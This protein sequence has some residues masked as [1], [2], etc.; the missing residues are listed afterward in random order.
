MTVKRSLHALKKPDA[1]WSV[2]N[3]AQKNIYGQYIYIFR[4]A[5]QVEAKGF[6]N[7]PFQS[8]SKIPAAISGYCPGD[9]VSENVHYNVHKTLYAPQQLT[10]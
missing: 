3:L 9:T 7:H 1:F 4:S 2:I 6:D 5:T 10:V 8:D